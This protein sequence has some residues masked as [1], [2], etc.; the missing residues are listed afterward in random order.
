MT[1]SLDLVTRSLEDATQAEFERRVDEQAANLVDTLEAGRLDSPD[2]AL[3]IELEVY[4]VSD[5]RLVRVPDDVFEA[6]CDREFGLHNAE[7]HTE[8]DTFDDEG[9][10]AQAEQL[11]RR[12]RES[13]QAAEREGLKFVLDA[14]WTVPPAEG[15]GEYLTDVREEEGLTIAQNM[16]PAARYRAIDNDVLE[17]AGGTV[18]LSVPGVDREFP[19]MLFESLT[20]S[21]QPHVQV[22]DSGAFPRY[23]N[24]AVRTLGPVLALATNSP[25]LPADCYDVDDPEGLLEDTYHELR[26]PV[27]E[28]SINDAWEKVRFPDDLEEPTDAVEYLRADPTCAPF[29]R[30]WLEDGDRKTFPERFWELDHKRGTYWRWLRAVTGGQPVGDGDRWSVRLEYRPLPTQPTITDNIGLQ[31][32]VAGLVRGLVETDH[33]LATLDREAAER[34]FYD[35]VEHGLEAD[36]AWITADGERVSDPDVVYDDLFSLARRGLREQG[37]SA[38]TIAEFLE[39]IETRWE[40]GRIPSQWKLERVREGLAEGKP[41]EDAIH[42][43]QTEY[44]RRSGTDEPFVRWSV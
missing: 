21:I 38:A 40:T 6:P 25:L 35:V 17:T 24:V 9:L 20:S 1:G 4:A 23:H 22:P 32:L 12:Y 19:T 29:L 41:L 31:A 16:T 11:R 27:F 2:F 8:P 18:S 34:C 37:I 7:L 13:Q 5:G 28:E 42:G 3:G 43:M 36:L 30:E 33:P 39:P 44:V 10:A 26:I 15:T 14:M